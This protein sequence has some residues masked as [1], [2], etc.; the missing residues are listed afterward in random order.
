MQFGSVLNMRS[1]LSEAGEGKTILI[2]L[3][4]HGHFDLAAYDSYLSGSMRDFEYSTEAVAA[5]M[6]DLPLVPA[7]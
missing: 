5:A 3:S 1:R 2:G 4:G 6:A 7:G